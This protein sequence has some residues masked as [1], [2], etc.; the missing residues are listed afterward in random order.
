ML[1]K[2][3]ECIHSALHDLAVVNNNYINIEYSINKKYDVTM[4]GEYEEGTFNVT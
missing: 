3:K 2:K 1:Y 4:L